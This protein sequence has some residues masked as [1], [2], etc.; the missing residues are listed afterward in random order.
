VGRRDVRIRRSRRRPWRSPRRSQPGPRTIPDIQHIVKDAN[1][2]DY[3]VI[4]GG[5]GD[6]YTYRIIEFVE[7][8]WKVEYWNGRQWTEL[9]VLSVPDHSTEEAIA[10]AHRIVTGWGGDDE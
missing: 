10:L 5:I 2:W 8:V 4:V 6:R 1:G 3:C 9:V 7:K